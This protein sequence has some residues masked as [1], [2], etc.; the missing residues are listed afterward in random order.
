MEPLLANPEVLKVDCETNAKGDRIWIRVAFD[1]AE[2]G[3]IFGRNGRTIQAIR[4]LLATTG[5]NHDQV[6]RFDV[7][8]PDPE[9][10]D[11]PVPVVSSSKPKLKPKLESQSE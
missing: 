4:T 1:P 2:K 5:N 9:P 8:D 10:K 7:F 3:R 11:K 6:V